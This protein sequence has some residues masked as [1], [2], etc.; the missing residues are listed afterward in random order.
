MKH[1][2]FFAALAAIVLASTACSE[3]K[4]SDTIIAQRVEKVAPAAPERMQEYTDSRSVAW[5]G[6]T[7]QVAVNRQP[8]D[9]LPLV[10]DETGQK[11]VDNVIHIKV[12]R[13]DG[14]VFFSRQFTKSD[15]KGFLDADEGLVFDKVDGDWLVFAAS[16]SHPHTDEYIPLVVRLSRMGVIVIRFDDSLDTNANEAQGSGESQTTTDEEL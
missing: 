6:K 3:K 5:I 1:V 16:V 12:S 14:S 4:K 9:S 13:Q 7:Y 10:K 15:F 8:A 11:F 2:C